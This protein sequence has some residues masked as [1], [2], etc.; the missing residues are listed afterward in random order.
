VIH[1]LFGCVRVCIG[2][3]E[4]FPRFLKDVF[5]RFHEVSADLGSRGAHEV[6]CDYMIVAWFRNKCYAE[7]WSGY[8]VN[9]IGLEKAF[10][11]HWDRDRQ[12][13]F[14]NRAAERARAAD[15]AA[16]DAAD[17]SSRSMTAVNLER[18]RAADAAAADAADAASRSMTGVAPTAWD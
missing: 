6:L 4:L 13:D 12:A 8:W 10:M 11:F 5:P 3:H 14:Q 9:D 2:F 18:A 16:A 17:A 1:I 15:A 7:A